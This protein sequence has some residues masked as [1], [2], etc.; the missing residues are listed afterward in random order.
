MSIDRS[1]TKRKRRGKCHG[2]HPTGVD[3]FR[4]SLRNEMNKMNIDGVNT[5]FYYSTKGWVGQSD[6]LPVPK[7]KGLETSWK[8]EIAVRNLTS[9]RLGQRVRPLIKLKVDKSARSLGSA[10]L[11]G[12]RVFAQD[13]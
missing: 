8:V 7:C 11:W 2:T 9:H 6:T 4:W 13:G 12:P 3:V 1:E 5:K 10:P